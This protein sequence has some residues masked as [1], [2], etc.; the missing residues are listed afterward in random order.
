MNLIAPLALSLCVA[1]TDLAEARK[2]ILIADFE[3]ADFGDWKATGEA[4]GRGPAHGTLPKQ[5]PVTGYLGRGLANSYHNGDDSQGT[6]TSPAFTVRRRRI[7]FLI[8]GGQF[9]GETC[10]NLLVA[11]KVVRT[12]TGKSRTPQDTEHLNWHS[13]DVR[14][15]DGKEARIEI[16]DKKTGGWGHITVDHI[17]QSDRQPPSERDHLLAAAEESVRRAV[18]RAR[19]DPTRPVY[20]VLPPANWMNDPNGPI[21]FKGHYHLFYQFNPYGDDWGHMHWGHV[22]SKDLVHWEHLPIALWPAKTQGEEHVFSGCAAVDKDGRLVLIYTSIGNRP[23]EQWAAVSEDDQATRFRKHPA[24]PLLTLKD[25][26]GL[27]IDDWRDPFVS[28]DGGRWLMVTGGHR[29]GGKG[30]IFLYSSDDLARWKYLGVPFAGKEDN[31]ECPN[32]FRLGDRWVL[33]YSPHGP[34][35]YY[36]GD[37]DAKAPKFTP[38]Y[39]GRMDGDNFYAPNCTEDPKGRR[40]L[41]G[42]VRGFKRD[43]GWNGGLTLPRVLGVLPDGR[44]SQEPAAELAA[45]RGKEWKLGRVKLDGNQVLHGVAGDA[46]EIVAEIAPGDAKAVGLRVRRS[47]DSKRAVEIR[48]D[49]KT[50]DVAGAKVPFTLAEGEKTLKLRVFLDRSVLEVYANGREA[51]TR[52]IDPGAKDL[53]VEFLVSGGAAVVRS[54][55]VWPMR[56]IW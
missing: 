1:S 23:P 32:F 50:L 28:R 42:W 45:L 54:L 44:L 13:W 24:N 2:D 53:G 36:T 35:R 7:N 27:K 20:H 21:Y 17:V 37:F 30:C 41:W 56:G 16:V 34:V 47:D 10:I 14:D 40:I 43:R 11:G 18:A 52:V 5:M 15:L 12:A 55:Q 51:V 25:H 49:G 48:F 38:G 26:G 46:L 8:G 3:G 4:F 19:N 31:W 9:P 39:H 29:A 6:L 33:I 22:R